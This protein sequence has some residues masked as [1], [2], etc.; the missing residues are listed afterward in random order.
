[1]L[2]SEG[3]GTV[4]TVAPTKLDKTIKESSA[5]YIICLFVIEGDEQGQGIDQK[6]ESLA[7]QFVATRFLRCPVPPRSHLCRR[8]GLS[9]APGFVVFY[10]DAIIAT[11]TV[12]DLE[13]RD[14]EDVEDALEQWL[15]RRKCLLVSS[16]DGGG[17]GA[18]NEGVG[19]ASGGG[20]DD[21]DEEGDAD[22]W[23]KPC[24]ECGRK[25][26]HQHIRSMYASTE[27]NDD[28]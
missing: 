4:T 12:L 9:S 17:G 23:Q 7:C 28:D 15:R 3:H 2:Q 13:C 21:D 10:G 8:F 14:D 24:E 20:N 27:A 26:P 5:E 22:E 19:V 11:C 18:V 1:M 6:L 16:T 25:Y